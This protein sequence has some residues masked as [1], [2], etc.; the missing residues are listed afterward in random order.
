MAAG[1]VVGFVFTYP[2]NWLLVSS[3]RRHGMGSKS[4]MRK[5]GHPHQGPVGAQPR[6]AAAPA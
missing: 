6:G 4:V 1:I 2:W 5:G 3:G